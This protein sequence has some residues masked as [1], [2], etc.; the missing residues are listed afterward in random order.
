MNFH[1]FCTKQY[2][3]NDLMKKIPG[4]RTGRKARIDEV[5]IDGCDLCKHNYEKKEI[6]FMPPTHRC[7]ARIDNRGDDKI[8]FD[9]LNIPLDCPWILPEE[10]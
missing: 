9:P 7:N 4:A 2:T 3:F 8:I 1:E 10:S 6:S 5:V